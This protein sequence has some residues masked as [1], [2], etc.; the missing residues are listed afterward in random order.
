MPPLARCRISFSTVVTGRP[1]GEFRRMRASRSVRPPF[2]RLQRWHALTK[3]SQR[4]LP[5]RRRGVTWSIV[6][7]T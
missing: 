1:G 6:N 3:F 4:R 2:T 5:P 7:L